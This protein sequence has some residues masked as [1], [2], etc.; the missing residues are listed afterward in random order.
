MSV[1]RSIGFMGLFAACLAAPAAGQATVDRPDP[2]TIVLVA[3]P[4]GAE[5]AG[6][7]ERAARSVADA[8]AHANVSV[9][10]STAGREMQERAQLVAERL[11][12]ERRPYDLT[13]IDPDRFAGWLLANVVPAN[14][15][16][17][18][19]V[20]VPPEVIPGMLRRTA[21]LQRPELGPIG[22]DELF[23]ISIFSAHASVVR[24]QLPPPAVRTAGN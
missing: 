22:D 11:G 18:V 15:A 24:A 12:V 9:V 10:Y 8:L 1:K 20:I 17:T 4:S 14:A 16:T 7:S 23:V 5:P 21:R 13:P 2:F 19:L 6:S 3:G